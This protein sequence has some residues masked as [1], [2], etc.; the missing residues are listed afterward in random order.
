M[1]VKRA[2]QAKP[3]VLLRRAR[4]ERG[5]S[6]QEVADLIGAPQAFMVTRW[7]NGTAFPGP[8]YREKLRTL[9]E[10][11][12]LELGLLKP[13]AE[14]FRS[15]PRA[16]VHDPTIPL[17]FLQTQT[18]VGRDQVLIHLQEQL[19]GCNALK[20]IA[21]D[22]LPGVGKTTLAAEL[23]LS[24]EVQGFFRDGVLWAG[25]GPQPNVQTHL[26]RWAAL[27]D[28]PETKNGSLADS[29]ALGQALRRGLWSRRVLL[30]LD[31]AWKIEDAL[32]YLVGGP[33]C[34]YLLTTRIPDVAIQFA[35]EQ[36]VHLPELSEEEGMYLLV[37]IAPMLRQTKPETL[38]SLVY[39]V[40]GLPLALT[41]MGNYLLLQGRHGQHRRLQAA[42]T[43]LQQAE[44][45]LRLAQPQAGI[46]RDPRLLAGTPLTLQAMIGLS[47]A[48]LDGTARQAL[49]ALSVFPAKPTTF[50]EEAA[51]AVTAA[52]A[53]VLDRLVDVGLLECR[54]TDRYML[55]QTIT[56]YA[57][58]Q[59]RADQ[60]AEQ[61]M[62]RYFTTY[63]GR[64]WEDSVAILQEHTPIMAALY[65]ALQI[66][67][68]DE[69]VRCLSGIASSL[70]KQGFSTFHKQLVWLAHES[71]KDRPDWQPL[72]I[73]IIN[74]LGD[75]LLENGTYEQAEALSEE[76]LALAHQLADPPILILMLSKRGKVAAE[77]HEYA[78]AGTFLQEAL[79][80][81]RQIDDSDAIS[82][83]L[84]NLA[85][86]PEVQ[87]KLRQAEAY[88]QEALALACQRRNTEQVQKIVSKLGDVAGKQE[89]F[90]QAEGHFREA[91][92]LARAEKDNDALTTSL[93]YAGWTYLR[94]DEY[95]RAKQC[96]QEALSLGQQMG[97]MRIVAGAL[98]LQAIIALKQG[99]IDQAHSFLQEVLT[100]A[101][102]INHW[103]HMSLFLMTKG[104]VALEEG[105]YA[106]ARDILQEGLTLARQIAHV[107][108]IPTLL[109]LLGSVT[110]SL[111]A[112]ESAYALLQEGLDFA[113][114]NEEMSWLK[115]TGLNE[116][117]RYY[118]L[119][120][121]YQ[122][123]I[124]SYQAVLT[125]FPANRRSL[126]GLAHE[127]L[128]RT[129]AE[130][131]EIGQATEHAQIALGI[132]EKIGH[133]RAR[134]VRGWLSL[135]LS[136]RIERDV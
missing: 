34:A 90:A 38:R 74:T 69:F 67:Y 19:C 35:G 136:H 41:L 9:F 93:L 92:A 133:G 97:R 58:S 81:A 88:L 59:P 28:L 8:G 7:E 132:F 33:H 113:D 96:L 47:D 65:L 45:R 104:W 82:V 131:G 6:Q 109:F 95:L 13:P 48:I 25:L 99:K 57:G 107:E 98:I 130:Q 37:Q 27:L 22:G 101:R 84:A 78:Q 123:A 46:E 10:K 15:D 40:G 125:S 124:A 80:L 56:D 1:S 44:E 53:E 71:T 134:T 127:G 39:E 91:L 115:G 108:Y 121:E 54:G 51:L 126:M 106:Q 55:H 85:S 120:G 87:G 14:S 89:K 75:I 100:S 23:A 49:Y 118:L 4:Q 36:N 86:V 119:R 68:Q 18:L 111:G 29:E 21:V 20:H 94:Q 26:G 66:G 102:Q 103:E 112:L 24:P 110:L 5:W 70:H 3:N 50:S 42:I 116:L 122:Q 62:V 12:S 117:G 79:A 72:V 60:Q 17:R 32:V 135:L 73:A 77:R 31:D 76:G 83:V 11:S 128:A 114:Q 43:Q 52:S 2:A 16:P 64:H 63:I 129:A 30:V 61:R 105:K